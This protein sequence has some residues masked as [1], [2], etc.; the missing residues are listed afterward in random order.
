[1]LVHLHIFF[2][3]LSLALLV[4]R[5]AMQLNGKNWR[6]IKLLKIL[7]H[8]S[9]TLLIVSGVVILYIF[10]FYIE[11]W[12]V[13]KFALLI[14]YIVFAAKLFSKKVS[15]PKPIFFWL[16]CANFIGAMLIAHLK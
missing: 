8:L 12:L 5:G 16:A 14:L 13:A 6:S 1:M 2:A 7:P 4:I 3:F 15:Q 10:T 11:W 9:D